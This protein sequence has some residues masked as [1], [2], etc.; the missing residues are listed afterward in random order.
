MTPTTAHS[1]MWSP[2]RLL[3]LAALIAVGACSSSDGVIR[4]GVA[5]PF[6]QSRGAS[7]RMAADLAATEINRSGGI[8]GRR[9]ELVFRD[10]GADAE[11]AVQV[12]QAFYDDASVV[13]VVGHL[14]SGTT[15]AAA[16][17]YNGGESPLVEI[18]PSASNPRLSDAGPYT[19]RV[20]PTDLLHGAR[21]A[22]WAAREVGA[23][24]A[25]VMYRNDDYGRGVRTIFKD[26]FSAQGGTIVADDPYL[27]D[28]PSFEPYLRRI[29][30]RGGAQVLMIAGTREGAEQILQALT[31]AGMRPAVMGGD[32][33]SG[34]ESDTVNA[35]GVLISTAYLPDRPGAENAAFVRAYRAANND[36]EP[37]HRGA[38]TYD[39][40][41][42]LALA[43]EATGP[44]RAAIR[45]YLAGFGSSR[46]AYEGV[47]GRI[48]FDE[49]GDVPD[50]DVVIG[51]ARGGRLVT[52]GR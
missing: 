31:A 22:E 16:P 20:C 4:I 13:A 14:T 29:Q 39:I 5:G 52:A 48:A 24:R 33:I 3:P 23:T 41:R 46:E 8:G 38:G 35:E 51:I 40:I 42:L 37:D 30:R 27:D 43:I 28:L 18:S 17:V 7:M 2:R 11:R 34:L 47:T 26:G 9:I 1:R 32:G 25:A 15:L 36:R 44:D 45:D 50:K 6:E 12:A 10:D 19:F 21:L 49:N